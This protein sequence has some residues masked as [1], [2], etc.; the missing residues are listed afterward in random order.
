MGVMGSGLGSLSLQGVYPMANEE[1]F[2]EYLKR[3]AADLRHARRRLHE[4]EA[5]QHEPIA[6]VAMSCRLPGPVKS[7]EELWEVLAAG[8]DTISEFPVDRGWEAESSSQPDP[9]RGGTPYARQGGF[10]YDACDFD[11]VF[12]GISP[13]EALAMDPQQRLLLEMSWEVFERAEISPASLRGSRTGVFV[14]GWSSGYSTDWDS[15]YLLT[16]STTS[17]MSGRIAYTLGL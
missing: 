6:I 4:V 11:P 9:D 14:G 8:T 13:R 2:L 3:T 16:A 5:R 15:G 7:P 17:V 10:V 1:K 12:F